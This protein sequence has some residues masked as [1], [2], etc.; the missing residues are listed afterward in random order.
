[1]SKVMEM[2]VMLLLLAT[3]TVASQQ[4]LFFYSALQPR[5]NSDWELLELEGVS[6]EAKSRGS[7]DKDVFGLLSRV[8]W[9]PII[10]VWT[11]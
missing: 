9:R 4:H 10:H 3:A 7:Q 11:L 8:K 6:E 5:L 1:M 2:I